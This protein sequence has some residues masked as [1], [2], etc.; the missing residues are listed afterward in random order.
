MFMYRPLVVIYSASVEFTEP[1]TAL[2]PR[3]KTSHYRRQSWCCEL[4]LGWKFV[5][6]R[7]ARIRSRGTIVALD[8]DCAANTCHHIECECRRWNVRATASALGT[9]TTDIHQGVGYV[10]FVP[11]AEVTSL[12]RSPR[13]RSRAARVGWIFPT[14]WPS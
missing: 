7:F 12:I 1:A 9:S 10:S 2:F 11:T 6:P 14:T 4:N 13:R 5:R 3:S 8:R